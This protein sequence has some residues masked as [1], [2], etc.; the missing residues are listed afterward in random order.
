MLVMLLVV[1]V[2]LAWPFE[3]GA[4]DVVAGVVVVA[5]TALLLRDRVR[6]E[7][8]VWPSPIRLFWLVIYSVVLAYYVIKAN[9][10]VAYRV[11]HPALPIR[12]GIVKVRTGLRERAAITALANSITLTPG[13]L[14]VSASEGGDLYVHWINVQSTV[15]ETATEHIVKRLEWFIKRIFE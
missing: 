12:P 6:A 9:F 3:G 11:L 14:T 1:W 5:L 7:S 10:D 4:Q 13:T 15:V 2:L 8:R